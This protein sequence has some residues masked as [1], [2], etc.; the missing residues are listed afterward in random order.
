MGHKSMKNYI[1][2][3][4][5]YITEDLYDFNEG[6]RLPIKSKNI[7]EGWGYNKATLLKHADPLT[8]FP[9]SNGF[10]WTRKNPKNPE[11]EIS[12]TEYDKLPFN[13]GDE[14]RQGIDIITY[15]PKIDQK[16][17][18][19]NVLDKDNTSYEKDVQVFTA[20]SCEGIQAFKDVP[21]YQQYFSQ[22]PSVEKIGN[23]SRYKNIYLVDAVV[24]YCEALGIKHKNIAIIDIRRIVK[25]EYQDLENF[26]KEFKYLNQT[27][28]LGYV[29]K[30]KESGSLPDLAE[31]LE[32]NYNEEPFENIKNN[33]EILDEINATLKDINILRND[34][35]LLKNFNDM[36][37]NQLEDNI[38]GKVSKTSKA[39]GSGQ[40]YIKSM[41]ENLY[42]RLKTPITDSDRDA[43]NALIRESVEYLD[44]YIKTQGIRN[45]DVIIPLGSSSSFNLD[46]ADH[47]RSTIP[48]A[49]AA[50]TIIMHK[51]S[52]LA[53]NYQRVENHVKNIILKA[54]AD[55]ISSKKI[56]VKNPEALKNGKINVTLTPNGFKTDPPAKDPTTGVI[57]WQ[58][59]MNRNSRE[60][61]QIGDPE[62]I[63][64]SI[65]ASG[66]EKVTNKATNQI[67]GSYVFLF[68]DI[69][70]AFIAE[71]MNIN[72]RL[73]FVLEN[74]T[75]IKSI[76]PA[77]LRFLVDVYD[78]PSFDNPDS[79]VL[80]VDDNLSS[81]ATTA[82]AYSKVASKLNSN[83]TIIVFVP[84]TIPSF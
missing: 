12:Y 80:V 36:T 81:G 30:R 14:N 9:D 44:E 4:A 65:C 70:D 18:T 79:V 51:T 54:M 6:I 55:P 83:A 33:S 27:Q 29:R 61:S 35:S 71:V 40:N 73:T 25:G 1:N 32:D 10:T 58:W 60:G 31:M 15:N 20:F 7:S 64:S 28:Y 72:E 47:I 8:N 41:T 50:N 62:A 38:L 52:S 69:D 13:K 82:N 34:L 59:R 63:K 56:D 39:P 45:I 24:N 76:Q 42:K 66:Y 57:N 67:T 16:V 5:N 37:I 49:K 26:Y 43:R 2:W 77:A 11:L 68:N 19:I 3:I 48:S 22:S 78:E 23:E 74:S 75:A 46:L 17:L 21:S 84:L 53:V